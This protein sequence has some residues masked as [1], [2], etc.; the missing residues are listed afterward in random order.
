MRSTGRGGRQP[1]PWC[2]RRGWVRE[3]RVSGGRGHGN[4]ATQ[5]KTTPQQLQRTYPPGWQPLTFFLF[6]RRTRRYAVP[7]RRRI[8]CPPA[9]DVAFLC[10][11]KTCLP[12]P[13]RRYHSNVLDCASAKY[14]HR[15]PT[16]DVHTSTL[17][18]PVI[19]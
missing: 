14:A 2:V 18:R 17:H 19:L 11:E 13:L 15:V 9:P 12:T 8:H 5:R 6:S 3:G 16:L 7:V 4:V 10:S 1:L